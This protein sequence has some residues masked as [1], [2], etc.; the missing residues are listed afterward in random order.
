MRRLAMRRVEGGRR[1]PLRRIPI[2][3]A[4]ALL[5]IL[6]VVPSV[7]VG[8]GNGTAQKGESSGVKGLAQQSDQSVAKVEHALHGLREFCT[9]S[10]ADLAN[11]ISK[12]LRDLNSHGTKISATSFI[13]SVE[14]GIGTAQV[15]NNSGPEKCKRVIAMMSTLSG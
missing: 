9:E 14:A 4:W 10:E 12:T 2:R 6:F 5:A 13:A 7:S 3:S 11:E 15:Q 1:G 8:C